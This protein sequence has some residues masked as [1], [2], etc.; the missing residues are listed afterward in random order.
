RSDIRA[1]SCFDGGSS[2][3]DRTADQPPIR[4]EQRRSSRFSVVVPVEVKWQEPSGKIVKQ[5]AQA[6]EVN[7][8]GGLLEMK[9]YPWVGGDLELTNLLSGQTTQARLVGTRR[10]K[11]GAFL[12]VA[13]ALVV[14]NEKSTILGT[15]RTH[16]AWC[17]SWGC[18]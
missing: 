15:T 18:R 3:D 4:P 9:I 7:A 5:A 14:P 6:K 11:D 13:V 2:M 12:G 10:S 1:V 8:Q 16:Q 17:F